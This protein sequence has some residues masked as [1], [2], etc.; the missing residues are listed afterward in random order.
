MSK[1]LILKFKNAKLF[2]NTFRSKDYVLDMYGH[3]RRNI[4]IDDDIHSD[5][6]FVEPITVYQVSNVLHVLFNERPVPSHREVVY[7]K[8][9]YYFDKALKSYIRVDGVK[10]LNTFTNK[11]EYVTELINTQ[12]GVNNSFNNK[13]FVNWEIVKQYAGL[14]NVEWLISEFAKI[15]GVNPLEYTFEEFRKILITKDFSELNVELR[16]KKITAISQY[17]TNTKLGYTLTAKRETSLI[18]N[19]GISKVAIL[20]GEIL[21]PVTDDDLDRLSTIS[22]GSATILDGG[23]VWISSVVDGDELSIDGFTLVENISTETYI[24]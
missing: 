20:R 9:E 21:V 24:A 5:P 15:T 22:K 23:F 10:R 19:R 18:V 11:E 2:R 1:Y 12:K 8:I 17:V 16:R 3:R 13:V 14:D 6:Q 7:P 4:K